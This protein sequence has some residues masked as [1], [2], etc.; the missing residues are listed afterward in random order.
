MSPG[1][2]TSTD[3]SEMTNTWMQRSP[4]TVSSNAA[5]GEFPS[6]IRG[7]LGMTNCQEREHTLERLNS[8]SGMKGPA[9]QTRSRDKMDGR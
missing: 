9:S 4:Q 1:V 7:S 3:L 5:P 6:S 2:C 8:S